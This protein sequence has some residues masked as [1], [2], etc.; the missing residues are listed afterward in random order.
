MVMEDTIDSERPVSSVAAD[1]TS[2]AWGE[3]LPAPPQPCHQGVTHLQ[4]PQLLD[5]L[6]PPLDG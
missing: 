6:L 4:F 5:G 1:S 2:P 3:L